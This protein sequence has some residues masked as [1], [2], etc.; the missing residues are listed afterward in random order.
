MLITI[1]TKK[2]WTQLA[3]ELGITYPSLCAHRA[4]LYRGCEDFRLIRN[5]QRKGDPP[6]DYQIY[7]HH[8]FKRLRDEIGKVSD[9]WA[10]N[11]IIKDN[12]IFS[13]EYYDESQKR[14]QETART[15][16][17]RTTRLLPR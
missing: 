15:G 8:E 3:Q 11:Q 16:K 2:N 6:T 5:C 1:S 7:C 17:Q 12:P 4:L 14:T 9:D 10:L 13:K